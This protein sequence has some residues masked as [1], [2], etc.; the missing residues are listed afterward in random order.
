MITTHLN[1]P[2]GPLLTDADVAESIRQGRLWAAT[3]QAN[4]ILSGLFGECAPEL[5]VCCAYEL[6]VTAA[7]AHALYR[8]MLALGMMRCPAWEEAAAHLVGQ[9][10]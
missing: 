9:P 5:I 10:L 8:E 6:G 1:A 3:R 4:E 2:Y 7:Q